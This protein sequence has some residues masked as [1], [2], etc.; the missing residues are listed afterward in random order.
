[1]ELAQKYRETCKA[2]DLDTNSKYL[3][4]FE[5]MTKIVVLAKKGKAKISNNLN[6]EES[7]PTACYTYFISDSGIP[8]KSDTYWSTTRTIEKKIVDCDDPR[9][10]QITFSSI[11]YTTG[12]SQDEL[13]RSTPPFQNHTFP[14]GSKATIVEFLSMIGQASSTWQAFVKNIR[15]FDGEKKYSFEVRWDLTTHR[16]SDGTKYEEV[17]KTFLA[18]RKQQIENF[19]SSITPCDTM[20]AKKTYLQFLLEFQEHYQALQIDSKLELKY[21][22][23]YKLVV[24]FIP[25]IQ[26]TIDATNNNAPQITNLENDTNLAGRVFKITTGINAQTNQIAGRLYYLRDTGNRDEPVRIEYQTEHFGDTKK[27]YVHVNTE[28]ATQIE[29]GFTRQLLQNA[30]QLIRLGPTSPFQPGDTEAALFGGPSALHRSGSSTLKISSS[31]GL[32]V[33]NWYSINDQEFA[34]TATDQCNRAASFGAKRVITIIPNPDPA[35]CPPP[36][37]VY[38]NII[39]ADQSAGTDIPNGATGTAPTL[40]PDNLTGVPILPPTALLANNLS[41]AEIVTYFNNNP[42]ETSYN[43]PLRWNRIP[44]PVPPSSYTIGLGFWIPAITNPTAALATLQPLIDYLCFYP[45][46]RVFICGWLRFRMPGTAALPTPR[47]NYPDPMRAAQSIPSNIIQP[48]DYIWAKAQVIQRFI[49]DNSM[50]NTSQ[51]QIPS[52]ANDPIINSRI[53]NSTALAQTVTIQR[54]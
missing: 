37:I 6:I 4:R 29:D 43:I 11:I 53:T 47:T 25:K 48:V 45:N 9:V 10:G 19:R 54:I 7:S 21:R 17:D 28:Q 40:I 31:I 15:D 41:A 1:M 30:V 18:K 36:T 39:A 33:P 16:N 46:E 8:Q 35:N 5:Y 27:I 2:N 13:I 34:V 49:L 52:G 12:L 14:K 32:T 24:E 23:F 26:Q 3:K 38:T 20:D 44:P 51:L 42:S 22:D 50:V